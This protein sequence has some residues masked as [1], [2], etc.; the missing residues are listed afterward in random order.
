[1]A[2]TRIGW[3]SSWGTDE[4]NETELPHFSLRAPLAPPIRGDRNGIPPAGNK[5]SL[6]GK[7]GRVG[8]DREARANRV[9]LPDD[10]AGNAAADV[11]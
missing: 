3:L 7:A 1:M 4:I 9:G 10:G 2:A 8:R 6:A 5:I 11:C